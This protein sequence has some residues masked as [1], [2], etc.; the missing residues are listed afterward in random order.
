[1][2]QAIRIAVVGCGNISD[3]YFRNLARFEGVEVVACADLDLDRARS[4]AER[5]GLARAGSLEEILRD[6]EV[7]LVLNLTTPEAHAS[8]ALAALRAGKH[9]YNEKPLAL[10]LSD[11]KRMLELAQSRGLRVGCAPDTFL[12]G[13][14]QTCIQLIDQGA[15]GVPVAASAFMTCPGHE[16]W[17]PNPA[18]YYQ[19]G[20]GPMFD[21][22]PYYL[23]TLV[24]LLGPVKRVT[25]QARIS[26]PERTITSQPKNG[27][28]ITV[29]TPTHVTG[30]MDFEGG[31]QGT[32]ITSFD[33]WAAK[34]PFI[35]IYG[36]EGSLS[37][38]DP[39]TFGGPV[40]L[41][42]RVEKVWKDVP[43]AQ[44]FTENSRGLGV[45]DM[46]LGIRDDREHRA[47]GDLALHVLEIMQG[48]LSSSRLGRHIEIQTRPA[49][50]APLRSGS[51]EPRLIGAP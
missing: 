34:L 37:L 46:A 47:S 2:T 32:I 20:A 14:V 25:G 33:V 36:S 39:N 13:G 17:H 1:M 4:T 8:V 21:M 6:P 41:L 3:I 10:E 43:V 19:P 45:T 31:A 49:R 12:G 22:G 5:Y 27:E 9:V 48:F 44:A 18:F 16:S 30:L 42:T 7:D 23:T 40:R 28:K 11:A 15:I 24:S 29:N 38:P 26:F 50:P 35:E 51:G